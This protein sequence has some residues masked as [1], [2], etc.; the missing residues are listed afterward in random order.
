[1][2]Q[3]ACVIVKP[4]TVGSYA[5]IF[6]CTTVARASDSLWVSLSSFRKWVV[7]WCYV[8]GLACCVV[9]RGFQL[10][11][12]AVFVGL[13]KIVLLYL[14]IVINFI[15]VFSLWCVHCAREPLCQDGKTA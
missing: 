12:L 6:N 3:I 4:I 10:L 1:M 2:R 9:T 5:L 14:I 13:S 15:F 8:L 7:A 11:W